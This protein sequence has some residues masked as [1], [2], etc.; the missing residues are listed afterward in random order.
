M[1]ALTRELRFAIRKAV[2]QEGARWPEAENRRC[3]TKARATLAVETPMPIS[4]LKKAATV[5]ARIF[6]LRPAPPKL[7][8]LSSS[9]RFLCDILQGSV[10]LAREADQHPH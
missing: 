3:R 9:L 8:R 1:H 10:Q 7:P 6:L 5:P 2:Q 4:V